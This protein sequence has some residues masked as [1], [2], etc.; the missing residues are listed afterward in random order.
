MLRTR[1]FRWSGRRRFLVFSLGFMALLVLVGFGVY[2][3]LLQGPIAIDSF[4]PRLAAALE[5]R[6]GKGW[7]FNLGEASLERG[8]H[9]A[10][11]SVGGLNIQANGR[12][13]LAAPRA[14]VSLD[15]LGL[16]MLQVR[17]RRLDVFDLEVQLS[18]RPDGSVAI[19]AGQDASQAVA[20]A[21][22]LETVA[23]PPGA[24]AGTS[25]TP[26]QALLKQAA[27]ALATLF[28]SIAGPDSPVGAIDRIAVA[29][30][31]LVIDDQKAKRRTVFGGL[32]LAFDKSEGT[33]TLNVS[34]DGPNGR[35]AATVQANGT[36][37][38]ER[39]LDLDIHDVTLDE[40]ALAGGWRKIGF[41][42]DMP[43]SLK[44]HL[45]LTPEGTVGAAHGRFVF[46]SGFFRL[47]DPDHEPIF[48]D[49]ITGGFLWTPAEHR[50][51][52]EPVQFFA[53]DTHFTV[54]GEVAPGTTPEDPWRI[55]LGL[56]EPGGFSAERPGEKPLAIE[57]SL[58]DGRLALA[59]RKFFIDR[60][61]ARGPNVGF[62]ASG[63]FDWAN[64]P[65]LKLGAS[66][67]PMPIHNLLRLWPTFMAANVR[68]WALTNIV[69]GTVPTATIAVDYNEADLTAMRLDK[70]PSDQS[71]LIDFTVADG[72]VTF[73]DGVAPLSG[74]SGQGHFTG[75]TSNFLATSGWIDAGGGR[76]LSLAEGSFHVSDSSLKPTQATL[77]LRANGSV[78]AVTEL[79]NTDA[80]KAYANLPLDPASLKG[81]IDGKLGVDLFLGAGAS[82]S[83]TVVRLNANVTNLSAE[84]LVGHEKLDNA[85][86]TIALDKSG[87][88]AT[89][90]G[91]LFGGAATLD[92]RKAAAAPGEA[93]INVILDEQARAK[94]GWSMS[95]VTGVVTARITSPLPAETGKAQVEFD[96][97]K[98]SLDGVLAGVVKPAGRPAK[99]AM[100]V[101]SGDQATLLDQIVV[102]AGSIQARGSAELGPENNLLSAKFPQLKLSPG[103]EMRVEAQKGDDGLKL[104][105]RGTAIDARPFIKYITRAGDEATAHGSSGS[106]FDIDLKTALLTGNNKQTISNAELR[107]VRHGGLVRQ[108]ALAGK[109]GRE[110]LTGSIGRTD[111]GV[112]RI[113][114][115]TN[116]AG[117]LIGFLDFYKRMEGGSLNA[118]MLVGES[119]VDGSIDVRDFMLRDE[120]AV[121][122]LVTEGAFRGTGKEATFDPTLVRFDRLQFMFARSGSRLEVRDGTMSGQQIGLTVDGWIDFTSDKVSLNGTFLPAFTVNNFF[123][124]IP[125]FGLFM[126]GSNEGLLGVNYGITGAMSSPTLNVNPLSAIA[127]G[128][129]RKIFGTGQGMAGQP[130]A[131][132]R[133]PAQSQPA[134]SPER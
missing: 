47:D 24:P 11:L 112:P 96:L 98:A 116:D 73:M 113:S 26:K 93:A 25:P 115:A 77:N 62:A 121:R 94:Q 66:A 117:S 27:A 65:H 49:E 32:E 71:T 130:G 10:T 21:P 84:K 89:G 5:E 36:A 7:R 70:V 100:A 56:T 75:H 78:D 13:V 118:Q 92:F 102:D 108:F 44:L 111:G 12:T 126:G 30:G 128:F 16:L 125:V 64:G 54:S 124:K 109:F 53:G 45:G 99:I 119:R 37:A 48:V 60:F 69:S 72:S 107:L 52:V 74:V 38:T 131:G 15:P 14:E 9:G 120:P 63:E 34:A 19:S 81:Q 85:N 35:W 83:D 68:R 67:S 58:F 90:Q 133:T 129:L 57:K 40:I 46:G 55:A 127:P 80:I 110:S 41:D 105:V 114:I 106:D 39:T 8:A 20:I 51:L 1:R 50:F 61:E 88:R 18:V 123:S 33:T 29:R 17:P 79:L 6:F 101:T 86:M 104:T 22:P 43:M 76:R 59:E 103:D 95:G 2:I 23:A 42:T 31:R 132:G 4:T 122:R 97:T 3:R 91:R 28:D 134:F 82:R 87:L